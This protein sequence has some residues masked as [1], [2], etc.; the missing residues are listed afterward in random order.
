MAP[1]SLFYRTEPG[2]VKARRWRGTRGDRLDPAD[3]K[4]AVGKRITV[5]AATD[6]H[7]Y[8][9]WAGLSDGLP[10]GDGPVRNHF[11]DAFLELRGLV[12]VVFLVI[13]AFQVVSNPPLSAFI[14]VHG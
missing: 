10:V 5:C 9:L 1:T 13:V 3:A 12:G 11:L 2:H 7:P 4:E 14:A 6:G 8:G